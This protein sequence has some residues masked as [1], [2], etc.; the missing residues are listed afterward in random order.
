MGWK[1]NVTPRALYLRKRNPAAIV[2]GWAPGA[3]LDW[4]EKSTTTSIFLYSLALC[5]YFI[6]TC[7]F[8][9]F[10]LHFT[11]YPLLTTQTSTPPA[12]FEPATVHPVTSPYTDWANPDQML[13]QWTI[14]LVPNLVT[15][16]VSQKKLPVH[17]SLSHTHT[18]THTYITNTYNSL[19]QTYVFPSTRFITPH[20]WAHTV[21]L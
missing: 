5:L 18:H 21:C 12:G 10:V 19:R 7:V 6:R 14:F 20:L 4:C 13:I 15:G 16:C 11:F 2:P 9:L 3:G 8:V 17:L 1:L